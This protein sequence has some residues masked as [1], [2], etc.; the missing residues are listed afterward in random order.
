[1]LKD[2]ASNIRKVSIFIVWRVCFHLPPC[3]K[4]DVHK[5]DMLPHLFNEVF[6]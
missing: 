3:N 1:M 4:N 6:Y 2:P 5:H